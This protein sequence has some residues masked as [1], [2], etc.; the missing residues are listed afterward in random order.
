MAPE[1]GLQNRAGQRLERTPAQAGAIDQHEPQQLQRDRRQR[2]GRQRQRRRHAR[3]ADIGAVQH[4]RRQ[5]RA[6]AVRADEEQHR[7]PVDPGL[8]PQRLRSPGRIAPARIGPVAQHR[9]R[10]LEG[11]RAEQA[12]VLAQRAVQRHHHPSGQQAVVAQ[13]RAGGQ[14]HRI[15]G[16]APRAQPG[17]TDAPAARA[18]LD[19]GHRQP[20][21]DHRARAEVAQS[22]QVM[23]LRQAEV[24]AG[25]L[26]A[27]D[28]AVADHRAQPGHHIRTVAGQHVVPARVAPGGDQAEQPVVQ[29]V[30]AVQPPRHDRP[31]QQ[32]GQRGHQQRPQRHAAQQRQRAAQRDPAQIGPV[33]RMAVTEQMQ[34]EALLEPPSRLARQQ[35]QPPQWQRQRH[36]AQ[37]QQLP[38]R[39]QP[40]AQRRRP[41]LRRH[42]AEFGGSRLGRHAVRM[43][44]GGQ[45]LAAQ[46]RRGMAE[47]AAVLHA[48]VDVEQRM[49]ADMA[50]L[51]DLDRAE[52]HPARLGPAAGQ[53][54][55]TADQAVVADAD[56]VGADRQHRGGDVRMRA[57]LRAQQPQ[58]AVEQRRAGEQHHR[59]E[60]HQLPHRPPAQ[61]A[62]APQREAAGLPA[63]DQQPLQRHREQHRQRPQ[64]RAGQRGPQIGLQ[65]IGGGQ[66]PVQPDQQG[67]EVQRQPGQRHQHLGQAA[68]QIGGAWCA[69]GRL[70][71]RLRHRFGHGRGGGGRGGCG[72]LQM[73]RERTQA[74]MRV[75]RA[76]R[77]VAASEL[78]AQP[79]AES[80]HQQRIGA[81]LIEEMGGGRQLVR[82]AAEHR[83]QRGGQRLLGARTRPLVRIHRLGAAGQR[84]RSRR[85]QRLA[86]GLVA[87][88]HRHLVELLVQARHHVVGQLRAQRL[89][90]SGRGGQIGPA[91]AHRPVGHQLDLAGRGRPGVHHRLAHA[92]LGHQHRLD[93][94]QLDAVAADLDLG[95]DAAEVLDPS[96]L[97]QAAEVAGAVEP[98]RRIRVHADE[99]VEKHPGGLFRP[100]Q[101][102]ARHA[103]AGND[104]LAGL[105]GRQHPGRV[106]IEDQ[107]AVGRQRPAD[108]D[109]RGRIESLQRRGDGGLGRAVGVEHAPRRRGPALHQIARTCLARDDQQPQL[110]QILLERGQR[111]GHAAQRG[112]VPPAQELAQIGAEQA[113]AA[114]VRMQRRAHAQRHPG[115]L[116]R[117]VEGHRQALVDLVVGLVAV[118]L[119][120]DPHEV[121]DLRVIDRHAFRAPGRAGG[122]DDIAQGV[123]RAA[124]RARQAG[125]VH[126][127]QSRLQHRVIQAQPRHAQSGQPAGMALHRQHPADLGIG[128][129]EG[130]ALVRKARVERHIGRAGLEHRQHRHMAVH[131]LVEQQRD[132]LARAQAQCVAQMP[133]QP[134]GAPVQLRVADRSFVG[135]QCGGAFGAAF[136]G[137]GIAARLEQM[138][139][140]L[141]RLPAQAVIGIGLL[142]QGR[143]RGRTVYDGCD[144]GLP[145]RLR[146]RGAACRPPHRPPRH[147]AAPDPARAAAAQCSAARAP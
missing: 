50:A 118:G 97:A 24:R 12:D 69:G 42:P 138:M 106:R 103:R 4:H 111:G 140:P 7:Q 31:R 90:Q 45:R 134:V 51:A 131:R 136:A 132:P 16:E 25:L 113:G 133:G 22:G 135:L 86:V 114:L 13:R 84:G 32:P 112:D 70:D 63:A 59:I 57:D 3:H 93:L 30:E 48:G 11:R 27:A 141:V 53:A 73:R 18:G 77:H 6:D 65:R 26:D 40:A 54:H 62:A 55:L 107:H 56:Q 137:P 33:R 72:L 64:R 38:Q 68:A 28:K 19:L 76:H 119:G 10:D 82:R 104:D 78:A 143:R 121:A 124:F 101:V 105:A 8:A 80:R 120:G 89:A 74:G 60:A 146:R 5:R 81:Q 100:V 92:G 102:A 94:G 147:A 14:Q 127:R 61:I 139:Q 117:E 47:L 85:G 129:D 123:R 109:R 88:Q 145:V 71:L 34:V 35:P 46:Q 23:L 79:R 20:V 44:A 115:F 21:G 96:V 75:D 142:Q 99:V 126:R 108:G 9:A 125:G 98:P 39:I 1:A 66:Q 52:P 41:G 130:A 83:G 49:V 29:P 15:A 17:R 87:G 58:I 37:H 144:P 116:D 110:G 2:A 43:H 36:A 122:V 128:A 91:G 95:V 67:L